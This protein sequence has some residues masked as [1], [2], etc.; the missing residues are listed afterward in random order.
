MKDQR[1]DKCGGR[2]TGSEQSMGAE[3]RAK[4]RSETFV[5]P[6]S[7]WAQLSFMPSATALAKIRGTLHLLH[8]VGWMVNGGWDPNQCFAQ[9]QNSP[10]L[11][12]LP[13]NS[14]HMF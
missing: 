14:T 5:P 2:I 12:W 10:P 11:V 8:P 9:A 7:H 6:P 13:Q 1:R 4:V 3:I